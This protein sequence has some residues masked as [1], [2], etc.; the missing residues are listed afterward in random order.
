MQDLEATPSAVSE[1]QDALLPARLPVLPR[2]ALAARY[3]LADSEDSGGDWFDA[4]PVPG[5]RVALM[6]GDMAGNGV[7]A[8]AAMGRL[9]AVLTERLAAGRSLEEAMQSLDRYAASVPETHGATVCA[10]LV[11]PESGVLEYTLA[12]HPPPLVVNRS[13]GHHFLPRTG[14][15]PLGTDGGRYDV[16]AERITSDDVVMLY[17]NGLLRSGRPTTVTARDRLARVARQ[18]V[19][20][21]PLPGIATGHALDVICDEVLEALVGEVG[22]LDDVALLVASPRRAQE[23]L[24]S[25]VPATDEHAEALRENLDDWLTELGAGLMDHVGVVHAFTEIVENV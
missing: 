20:Q 7:E 10:M 14:G 9:Q 13:G 11:D 17:S 19:A 1:V 6:V 15:S 16:V 3:L 18:V 5:G 4:V 25:I 21:E 2:L 8:A 22:P 24:V 23:G 12:G